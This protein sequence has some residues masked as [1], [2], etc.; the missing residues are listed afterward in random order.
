[1]AGHAGQFCMSNLNLLFLCENVFVL[2]ISNL[3]SI[4]KELFLFYW[5]RRCDGGGELRRA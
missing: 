5:P 2:F 1:M 3:S 4:R